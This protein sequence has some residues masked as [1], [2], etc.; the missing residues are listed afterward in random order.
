MKITQDFIEAGASTTGAWNYAQLRILGVETPPKAGWRQRIEGME[1]SQAEA[2]RFLSLN[3]KT[4]SVQ[5]KERQ[6]AHIPPL[7]AKPIPSERTRVGFFW[8]GEDK[9][10]FLGKTIVDIPSG[11]TIE[12]RRDAD[13]IYNL[14][15]ESKPVVES[16]AVAA[17]KPK[18]INA[19]KFPPPDDGE[20]IDDGLG[21]P[22]TPGKF[23]KH[24]DGTVEWIK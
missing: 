13:G 10:S 18:S 17:K 21:I 23:F 24:G 4:K 7:L 3:G 19:H 2:D 22:F 20:F 6:A 5:N 16:A 12:L 11:S 14:T 15:V 9:K 1:I 8:I